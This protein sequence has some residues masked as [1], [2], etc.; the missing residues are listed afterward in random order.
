MPIKLNAKFANKMP[1]N[2]NEWQQFFPPTWSDL[3]CNIV[4][5]E[6]G[7][8]RFIFPTMNSHIFN[9]KMLIPLG[10]HEILKRLM[11]GSKVSNDL[12]LLR[13]VWLKANN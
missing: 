13:W 12:M 3:S 2:L 4:F 1:I 5:G 9:E 6:A 10:I 8:F 7:N 11:L